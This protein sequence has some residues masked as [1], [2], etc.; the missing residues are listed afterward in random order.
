MN[1]EIDHEYTM[2][3]VCPYCGYEDKDGWELSDNDGETYCGRCD[4]EFSYTRN[5]SISYC[6]SKIE[7]ED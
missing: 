4:E 3:L 5:I 2:N 7:K 6:T 1:K